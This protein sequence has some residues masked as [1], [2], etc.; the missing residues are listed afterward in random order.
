M[1][2]LHSNKY[3]HIPS[4]QSTS[5]IQGRQVQLDSNT[6]FLPYH[7]I[8]DENNE[9]TSPS[10]INDSSSTMK[11]YRIKELF[12]HAIP[13]FINCQ[14]LWS[15]IHIS[16]LS[17]LFILYVTK[18]TL[19][20]AHTVAICELLLNILVINENFI[21]LLQYLLGWI[22]FLKYEIHRTIHCIDN[23]HSSIAFTAFFWFC[24]VLTFECHDLSV[25]ITVG[26][27]LFIIILLCHMK[28][29]TTQPY[30]SN[31]SESI[32]RYLGFTCFIVLIIHV[33]FLYLTKSIFN[34]PVMALITTLLIICS[35]GKYTKYKRLP[36]HL[37]LVTLPRKLGPFDSSSCIMLDGY[38]WHTYNITLPDQNTDG[39]LILEDQE[40]NKSL[41]YIWGRKIKRRTFLYSIHAYRRVLIVC[42][43]SDIVSILPFIKESLSTT[44]IHL[45]WIG[46]QYEANYGEY[47]WKLVQKMSPNFTLHDTRIS[48]EVNPDLIEHHFCKTDSEAVFILSTKTF[49][50]EV[51]NTLWLKGI[52][53]FGDLFD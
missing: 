11:M 5:P 47:I 10:K 45:L 8:S 51:M 40:T 32:H 17:L 46:Q 36:K 18:T 42:T 2:S 33:S 22:P 52:D 27:I 39:Y 9:T 37:K 50:A 6:I 1:N 44:H 4:D 35:P 29:S 34:V 15:A 16:I 41:E 49:T 38:Q 28:F 26:I 13:D 20:S 48:G 3:I 53:C 19:F 25:L 31:T 14:R 24:L 43:G 23:L 30:F 12:R 21:G 7:G